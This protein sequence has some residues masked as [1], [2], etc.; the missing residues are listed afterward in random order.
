MAWA[1][2]S[3]MARANYFVFQGPPT[4]MHTTG[5]FSCDPGERGLPKEDPPS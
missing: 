4:K 3:H 2:I 1:V 5:D